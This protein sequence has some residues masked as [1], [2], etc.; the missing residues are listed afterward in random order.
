M[1]KRVRYRYMRERGGK[2]NT[3]DSLSTFS[4]WVREFDPADR[5]FVA[6]LTWIE[7]TPDDLRERVERLEGA[8]LCFEEDNAPMRIELPCGHEADLPQ[9]TG[10]RESACK[11]C[12]RVFKVTATAKLTI[13][14]EESGQQG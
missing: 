5:L 9:R 11:T 3:T 1:A 14:M 4:K 6:R 7:C 12:Q 10:V 8:A 2:T 13:E